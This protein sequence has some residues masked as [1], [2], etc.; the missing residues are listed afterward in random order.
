MLKQYKIHQPRI[1]TSSTINEF[2]IHKKFS[3]NLSFGCKDSSNHTKF[4]K[5][6]GGFPEAFFYD[7]KGNYIPYKEEA[8]SCNG[9]VW[10]FIDSLINYQKKPESMPHLALENTLKNKINL[11]DMKEYS[12]NDLPNSDFFVVFVYAEYIGKMN[13]EKTF[14]WLQHIDKVNQQGKI[15]ITPILISV[16]YFDFWGITKKDIPKYK[17]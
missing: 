11:S 5:E 2:L 8:N 4:L 1:Q 6:I 9:G 3:N 7:S 17:Y 16:D 10:P 13:D 15:K 12:M 14:D